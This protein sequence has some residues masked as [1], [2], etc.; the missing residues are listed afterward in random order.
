MKFIYPLRSLKWLTI[1]ILV[2]GLMVLVVQFWPQK[3]EVTVNAAEVIP[4]KKG[5]FSSNLA[6]D[7]TLEDSTGQKVSLSDFIGK[8]VVLNF[9]ATWCGPCQAEMPHMQ[10]KWQEYNTKGSDLVYLLV[11]VGES[12]AVVEKFFKD[13]AYTMPVVFDPSS[14]VFSQYLLRGIPATLFINREG[15][16]KARYN[17]Y[18]SAEIL[19]ENITIITGES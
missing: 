19:Q 13:K 11:N 12:K 3:G 6:L 9:F 16:I 5:V 4:P 17:Q 18:I 15:V 7:F 2:L 1:L 14:K 10:K 8:P